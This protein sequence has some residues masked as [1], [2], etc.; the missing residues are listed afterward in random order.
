MLIH[1]LGSSGADWA[2][3]IPALGPHF[4]MIMPDLR[5]SGRSHKPKQRYEIAEFGTD[6]WSLLDALKIDRVSLLGFSLGGA[7]AL[8][9]AVLRPHSVTR[10]VLVNSLP[11]YVIRD[12]RRWLETRVQA[13]MVRV[14][15]PRSQRAPDRATAISVCTAGGAARASGRRGRCEFPARVSRHHSRAGRLEHTRSHQHI[16]VSD[17]DAGRRE[18]LHAA[19]GKARLRR[20]AGCRIRRRARLAPRHAVRQHPRNQCLRARVS[21]G[22]A[23]ARRWQSAHRSEDEVPLAE[24]P[25]KAPQSTLRETNLIRECNGVHQSLCAVTSL[26]DSVRTFRMQP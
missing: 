9:M 21:S 11:D 2:F 3:Q 13:A 4:H 6:L 22:S 23:I 1:G 26:S 24:I 17:P 5:G 10:M 18:R 20:E 16:A 14:L 15:G 8:E 19:C 12:R 25:S 7:V